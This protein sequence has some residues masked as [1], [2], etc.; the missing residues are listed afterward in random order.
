M[1]IVILGLA[2][3]SSW[4]NGHA[5]TYRA[6]VRGL[7]SRGHNVLFL[8]RDEP[9]YAQNR[10][11]PAP[12]YCRV[13]LYYHADELEQNHAA[14]VER[15]DLVIVGSYVPEG[16]SIVDWVLSRAQGCTAFYDID[17]PVTLAA[18]EGDA[19]PYIARRQVPLFDL[20]LS[21]TSGPTLQRLEHH[22]GARRARPL[23]CSVDSDIYYEDASIER[24]RDLGYLGTYSADRQP[25]VNELLLAPA[26]AWAEGRFVLAGPQY[27]DSIEAPVNVERLTHVAPHEHRQF[28]NRLRFTLN[29]TRRS[30]VEAGYS[31]SVRLFEAAACGTPIISDEWPGLD[32]FLEPGEEILVARNSADVL[33]CLREMPEDERR[34]LGI[35]ARARILTAHSADHRAMELERYVAEVAR[36]PLS[37]SRRTAVPIQAGDSA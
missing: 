27:P 30:M 7:S 17:T 10:D 6:L 8:E 21:F 16:R 15:A 31:P 26:R 36:V 20:Y 35:R 3:T 4:G 13:G 11:L 32:M 1:N 2:V 9:W 19:A 5:T 34:A 29:V 24:D 23:F 25:A 12:P 28:Y 14:D 18:L 37:A 22:F 33:A